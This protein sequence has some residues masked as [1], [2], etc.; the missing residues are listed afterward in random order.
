MLGAGVELVEAN[1]I[2]DWAAQLAGLGGVISLDSGPLHLANALGL[3]VIGLFGPGKLP[4]WEPSG[5]GSFAVHHQDRPGFAP[6][7]QIGAN[8]ARARQYMEWITVNDVIQKA[9]QWTRP[10]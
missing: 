1:S 5:P 7:H 8:I 2:P 3:R 10:A 4:M 9:A 6:I